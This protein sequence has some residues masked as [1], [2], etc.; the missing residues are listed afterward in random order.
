MKLRVLAILIMLIMVGIAWAVFQYQV[1]IQNR[2][3]VV[4]I[5]INAYAD[6]NCTT[7]LDCI[8][9]GMLFP[10]D[11]VTHEFY[12]LNEGNIPMNTTVYTDEWMFWD[13]NGTLVNITTPSDYILVS[14]SVPDV[15]EPGQ[16]VPCFI[17]LHVVDRYD[18]PFVS[19]A[20]TLYINGEYYE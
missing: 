14:W 8:D 20:F 3:R 6:S 2:T 17:T 15:I 10:N 13:Y 11:T 7:I 4:V 16:I 18:F 9:W 12:L 1:E 19:F 5:G